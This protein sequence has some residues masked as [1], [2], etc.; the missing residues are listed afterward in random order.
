MNII[1][2]G[3]GKVGVTVLQNLVAEGHDVT[4][5]DSDPAVLQEVTEI[6]DVMGV[7]GNGADSQVLKEA[8]VEQAELFVA[9]TG[10]DEFNMLSC[11]LARKLGVKH[12]IA[13]IRNPEYN[14]AGLEFV[15]NNLE[16]SGAINPDMLAAQELYYIL[17]L[18]SAMKI[19]HFAHRKFQIVELLLKE[20]SQLVGKP[21]SEI[22]SRYQDKFLVCAV[23][24][25]DEVFI[26]DGNSVL[27]GGDRIGLTAPTAELMPVMRSL[28]LAKKQV[29]DVMLLGGSRTAFY[30]AKRLLAAGN[31]VKIIDSD[32]TVC[33]S[34]SELL[35]KASVI[36]GDGAQQE[37][38]LEEGLRNMDAFV[39]LTG[40]DEENILVSCFANVQGVPKVIAKINRDEQGSLAEKLGLECIVSPRRIVADVVVRYARAIENSL[41]SSVETLY[42]LMDGKAEALEF[43]VREAPR[44]V[45]VPLK[46]LALKPRILI[47]G[48]VREGVTV[49]PNGNDCILSGDRVVVLAADRR[50]NDLSDILR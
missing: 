48:I 24:R 18:P 9:A 3:C 44:I 27:Q 33:E 12:T 13:R 2:V 1:V 22:R 29:K 20:D 39:A 15:K 32:R 8:S 49:I 11:F 45:G 34:L 37:L 7:C 17:K 19:E 4:V 41:G 14:G 28:G 5:I 23:Q 16:L 21:L 46:D 40:M 47:A 35:P 26:P 25:G 43:K 6:S 38:L 31:Q 30:L 50:L 36:C 10:S 42:K